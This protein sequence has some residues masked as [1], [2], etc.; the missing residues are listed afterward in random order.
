MSI[1]T[2]STYAPVRD[3]I[4]SPPLLCLK[5]IRVHN[6][7]MLAAF[8]HAITAGS[9]SPALTGANSAVTIRRKGAR[10]EKDAKTARN[11]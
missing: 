11:A 3:A 5:C 7:V 8:R 10:L 6:N 2:R 9:A 4:H 1:G